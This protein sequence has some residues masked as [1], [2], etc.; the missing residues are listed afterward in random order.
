MAW[1]EKQRRVG[2]GS[3][4]QNVARADGFKRMVEAAGQRWP[5]GW[6]KGEESI[7]NASS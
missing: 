4:A 7:P 2:G 1:I 3:D 6:V 5:D